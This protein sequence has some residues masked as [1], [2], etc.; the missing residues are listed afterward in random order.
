MLLLA[1]CPWLPNP[2]RVIV[3]SG[4]RFRDTGFRDDVDTDLDADADAD[5]DLDADSDADSDTDPGTDTDTPVEAAITGV[6]LRSDVVRVTFG[7]S[8]NDLTAWSLAGAPGGAV[9]GDFRPPVWDGSEGTVDLAWPLGCA[10]VAGSVTLEVTS[11]DGTATD[12]APVDVP[13]ADVDG[14]PNALGVSP[15]FIACGVV[16]PPSEEDC[17]SW[18]QAG[19]AQVVLRWEGPAGTELETS[20]NTVSVGVDAGS[21]VRPLAL[22]DGDVVEACVRREG[23]G[24]PAATP[25]M[26]VLHW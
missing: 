24:N 11:L 8:G 7:A 4:F 12:V 14:D 10:A 5:S 13:Y 1:G 26:L 22:A 3:D 15:P 23:S 2:P 21:A 18:S 17:A 16:D 9:Q 25:W 19:P 20:V 6:E